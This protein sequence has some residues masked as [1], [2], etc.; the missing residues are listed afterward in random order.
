VRNTFLVKIV[1]S[2]RDLL[3]ESAAHWLFDLAV[4]ALLLDV[5]M[6]TYAADV[7]GHDANCLRGFN[8][9]MH[10]DDIGVINLF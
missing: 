9:I 6:Q 8:Q 10:L 4:G 7:V 5:L 2:L 1:K 3:E